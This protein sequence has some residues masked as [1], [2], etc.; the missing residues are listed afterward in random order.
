MY[1]DMGWEWEVWRIGRGFEKNRVR[2]MVGVGM[3]RG[4]ITR[5]GDREFGAG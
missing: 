5:G 2:V 3:G 1:V 4:L